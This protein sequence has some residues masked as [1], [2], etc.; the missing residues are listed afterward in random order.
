MVNTLGYRLDIP[1]FNEKNWKPLG[2]GAYKVAHISSEPFCIDGI[3]TP[4]VA[5]TPKEFDEDDDAD[6]A[7]PERFIRKNAEVN[8]DLPAYYLKSYAIVVTNA[9]PQKMLQ[10]TVYLFQRPPN[11][12]FTSFKNALGVVKVCLLN[13]KLKPKELDFF[14]ALIT[15]QKPLNLYLTNL[16][17]KHIGLE[18]NLS[19][20]PYLGDA[21]PSDEEIAKA[22]IE[23]Y[24][25]TRNIIIDASVKGNFIKKNNKIYCVD[26]DFAFRRGSFASDDYMSCPLGQAK[27]YDFLYK[28]VR[29]S[30]SRNTA[31]VIVALL[32]LEQCLKPDEI[33][34]SYIDARLL[35]K[36]LVLRALSIRLT[37][38]KMEA[39]LF[40]I[41]NYPEH[42]TKQHLIT[43]HFLEVLRRQLMDKS[44]SKDSTIEMIENYFQKAESKPAQER[45]LFAFFSEAIVETSSTSTLGISEP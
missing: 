17:L 36:Y 8:P 18:P 33:L 43:G 11:Q 13:L 30:E 25:R 6:I 3:E 44:A 19:L 10:K 1:T 23:I 12:V 2:Q 4:W 21:R 38:L 37:S 39:L 26:L 35:E 24:R 34:D 9:P 27:I 14:L 41:L 22:T 28:S 7:N 42:Q 5:K 31:L 40:L 45:R 20:M 32:Y 15:N 29:A 16:I